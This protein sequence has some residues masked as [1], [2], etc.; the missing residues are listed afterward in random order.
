MYYPDTV[1]HVNLAREGT[2][3]GGLSS[4]LFVSGL[5]VCGR[6]IQMAGRHSGPQPSR[7]S[8]CCH[9]NHNSYS[10]DTRSGRRDS[11]SVLRRVAS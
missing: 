8:S 2:L 11:S 7:T 5:G 9:R 3:A 6:N 1:L 4:R 10:S